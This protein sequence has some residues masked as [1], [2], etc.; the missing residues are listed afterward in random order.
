MVGTIQ[1][2]ATVDYAILMTSRYQ[3]ERHMGRTKKESISIAH[4][5]CMKSIVISGCSFFAATIGV[6]IYSQVDMISAICTLL[7]RGAIISMLVVLLVLP[8]MFMVFDP[9]ICHT[10]IGFLPPKE[11]R[12][13]KA[14]Q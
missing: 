6:V 8:A 7:S 9:V 4:K 5:A 1:L 14:Q 2:G 13:K 3:K 11:K 12:N 10:S